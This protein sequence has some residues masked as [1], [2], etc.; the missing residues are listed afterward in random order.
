MR[1][2][3]GIRS[4]RRKPALVAFPP[5]QF[6]HDLCWD[7][8]RAA[9]VGDL[10]YDTALQTVVVGHTTSSGNVTL[11][12]FYCTLSILSLTFASKKL[13]DIFS[14]RG[15][16]SMVLVI[17]Y[18]IRNY[19]VFFGVCSS[20]GVLKTHRFGNWVCFRPQAKWLKHL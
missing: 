4:T 20:S 3:R 8:P 16:S 6:P 10:S 5:I 18:N 9:M 7:Q 15:M 13:R 1:I 2:G 14:S 11:F 19:R 17:M 12:N